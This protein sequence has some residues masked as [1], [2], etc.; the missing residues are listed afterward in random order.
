MISISV[1]KVL[2]VVI[3]F[4]VS[5][6]VRW[7]FSHIR[8]PRP[9][10]DVIE[11]QKIADFSF[12]GVTTL[13]QRLEV[14]AKPNNRLILAFKLDNSFTTCDQRVHQEFLGEAKNAIGRVHRDSWVKFGA[15]AQTILNS[16]LKYLEDAPP[17]IPLA[18]LVRVV[19]FSF[20]IHVLFRIEPS[21]I[22][23]GEVKNAT[24]AINRLWVQ[25]KD[26]NSIPSLRDRRLLD[27][28]LETL[29]R[30]EFSRN[31]HTRPLNLIMPAYETLWRVVL[32][33]FVSIANQNEDP[34]T[35]K[36]LHEAIKNVPQCF[37]QK[38]KAEMR[39]LAIAKEGL[40][41]YPP[42]KRIYR[43][44][45][46]ADGENGV[47]AA[48]VE[49]CHREYRFWGPDALQ[50]KP[51]RFHDWPREGRAKPLSRTTVLNR[52]VEWLETQSYF[53]F[54]VGGHICPAAGGFGEKII[55][56]LVVELTRRFKT[57]QSGLII[58]FGNVQV[59]E[60]NSTPLP[61]G[62]G[63]MENWVL[64]VEGGD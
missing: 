54:G 30:N 24:E 2:L 43:A 32:L 64:E 6:C 49:K 18:S 19:S 23:L 42:T 27:K 14:R 56:L 47:V 11:H 51:M 35:T 40:R 28:A 25:S 12:L 1:R 41:L 58:H 50:F 8:R 45:S 48:D 46:T 36:E 55:T 13:G 5:C 37:S 17:Y 4:L 29:F 59:Q 9:T 15:V 60:R 57:R 20:V 7:C 52:H 44:T 16:S 34:Q 3:S 39:A 38:D 22:D 26:P 33:T 31:N 21:D 53:P 63:D 62:R 10:L 61:S